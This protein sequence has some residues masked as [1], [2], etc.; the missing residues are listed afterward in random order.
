M[1]LVGLL[2]ALEFDGVAVRIS[3][4]ERIAESHRA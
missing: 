4:L 2:H 1:I 3:N